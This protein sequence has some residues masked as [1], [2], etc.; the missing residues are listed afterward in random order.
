MSILAWHLSS[1]LCKR[2]TT[3][4][5]CR[6]PY[7][8]PFS[9][10]RAPLITPAVVS[11]TDW[12]WLL[13]KQ[14]SIPSQQ[15][16]TPDTQKTCGKDIDKTALHSGCPLCLTICKIL[17]HQ[18]CNVR[19]VQDLCAPVCRESP[20]EHGEDQRPHNDVSGRSVFHERSLRRVNHSQNQ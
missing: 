2:D 9:R 17:P 14:P 13:R 8:D 16:K 19:H 3:Q 5:V 20:G 4:D 10:H 6:L 15:R 7:F 18:C 11:R 12:L 1:V